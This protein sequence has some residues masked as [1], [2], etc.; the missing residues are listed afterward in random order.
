MGLDKKFNK[1]PVLENQA[2]NKQ[3]LTFQDAEQAPASQFQGITPAQFS[4]RTTTILAQTIGFATIP[5]SSMKNVSSR[6]EK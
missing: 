3:H 2:L 4:Q 6:C 1:E 5:S